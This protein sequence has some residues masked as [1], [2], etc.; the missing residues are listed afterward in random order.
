MLSYKKIPG[1]FMGAVMLATLLF[2]KGFAAAEISIVQYSLKTGDSALIY[3]QPNRLYIS[4]R[5]DGDDDYYNTVSASYT[6]GGKTYNIG[7]NPIYVILG[8]YNTSS[9][10]F[11]F[12]PADVGKAEFSLVAGS[13][14]ANFTKD[15]SGDNDGDGIID[16]NDPDDDNDGMPDEWESKY[17]LD[18]F[19]NKDAAT[20]LDGDGLTNLEEYKLGTDPTNKD[21]DGDGMP[22]E[23][24]NYYGLNPNDPTD[25]NKDLDGDG[26]TN[27]EEYQK[28]TNPKVKDTDGDGVLDG[29]DLYPL[30]PSKWNDGS[31]SNTGGGGNT[32]NKDTDGDGMPDEWENY[33]GLNPN[34][35]TDANKDLDGDG[36]TNLEEYQKG[37]NPKV[38]D[39]DGD[40]VGDK[41]D[42][43][44]LNPNY[45]K[46]TDGDGMPDE[47]EIKYGLNPKD[48]SDANKDLDGD[49]L[50][51]LEEFKL[52]TDP[53]KKDTDGDG[54]NDKEDPEP[55]NP[56]YKKDEDG[57]GMP[58]EWENNNGLNP[59]DGGDSKTDKDEDGLN[60]LDEFN[61]GTDPNNKDTDGDGVLDGKDKFPLDHRY[62][63]DSDGDGMPDE[64][65]SQ[66]GLDPN[67]ASDANQ[68]LDGDGISNL[69]EYL[70]G[71]NPKEKNSNKYQVSDGTLYSDRGSC[72][73]TSKNPLD[74]DSDW[75]K[76]K[77][78][79]KYNL[80]VCDK[81]T[82]WIIPDFI[83]YLFIRFWWMLLIIAA[84]ITTYLKRQRI[85][86]L[87]E[88]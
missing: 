59:K 72:L 18:Q 38:K 62:A 51:N 13:E 35:P 61:A 66:Y 7:T 74:S 23:W 78:E 87:L 44:P 4:V 67:N 52:G 69:K 50:T 82:Y 27:L 85:K 33:Y 48:A 28:G 54:V 64:W 86:E 65:E 26:L 2:Q 30:D 17:G 5:N 42:S 15:I 81:T 25:A 76:N 45:N 1:I 34:D 60:N 63:N 16:S 56:N 73:V 70:A 49:G 3:N 14:E 75:L 19:S 68:D 21:T 6:V 39:T 47:W 32:N 24:E 41:E 29:D 79:E 8:K 36:L 12:T 10:Y 88:P 84:G 55:L 58:D 71:T 31:G 57:D 83:S 11:D 40:G 22:D 20:D 77:T 46:D 9:T 43:D 80:H 53:T 37:T